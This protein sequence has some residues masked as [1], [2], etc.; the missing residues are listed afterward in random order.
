[1]YW[2]L[3]PPSMETLG[4]EVSDC[5]MVALNLKAIAFFFFLLISVRSIHWW[6]SRNTDKNT[7]N[8]EIADLGRFSFL[9]EQVSHESLAVA[10]DGCKPV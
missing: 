7:N 9:E 10:K 2:T 6:K 8:V 5:L 1:M 4:L 3:L